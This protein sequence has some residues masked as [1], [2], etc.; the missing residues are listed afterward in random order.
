MCSYLRSLVSRLIGINRPVVRQAEQDRTV[1]TKRVQ[2]I[3]ATLHKKEELRLTAQL[4]LARATELADD[5]QRFKPKTS[6]SSLYRNRVNMYY[7][8]L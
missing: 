1:L 7:E 2:E 3:E 6:I 8:T 5:A 4:K